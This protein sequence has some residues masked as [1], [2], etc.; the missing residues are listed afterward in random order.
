MPGVIRDL[1]A[2]G[3]R[4]RTVNSNARVHLVPTGMSHHPTIRRSLGG[5]R[6]LF[7]TMVHS[8]HFRSDGRGR[9]AQAGGILV[10]AK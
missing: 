7:G 8:P 3:Q 1:G 9:L 4:A 2:S 5:E 6:P 10:S